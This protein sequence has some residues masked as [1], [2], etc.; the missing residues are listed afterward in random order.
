MGMIRVRGIPRKPA[1]LT[2]Q[3]G[4]SIED[5]RLLASDR[6]VYLVI[7]YG[8]SRSAAF[9]SGIRDVAWR[10]WETSLLLMRCEKTGLGFPVEWLRSGQVDQGAPL[11]GSLTMRKYRTIN[12]ADRHRLHNHRR[13]RYDRRRSHRHRHFD[14]LHHRS[15]PDRHRPH[16]PPVA[17]LR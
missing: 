4:S 6:R 9:P 10:C 3:E 14:H 7:E 11:R 8:L 1:D 5:T 16:A 17:W 12:N 15:R 2:P 13:R